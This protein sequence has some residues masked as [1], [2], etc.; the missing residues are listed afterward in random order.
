[1]ENVFICI[2]SNTKSNICSFRC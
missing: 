1:M 2:K